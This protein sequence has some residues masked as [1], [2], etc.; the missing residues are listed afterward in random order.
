LGIEAKG[1]WLKAKG[2]TIL[3]RLH[4]SQLP[5]FPTSHLPSFT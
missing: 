2:Q 1:K 3:R 4:F 5:I